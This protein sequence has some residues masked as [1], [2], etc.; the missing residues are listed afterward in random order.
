M[1]RGLE[2]FGLAKVNARSMAASVVHA[3]DSLPSFSRVPELETIETLYCPFCGYK[4]H[5]ESDC[6]IKTRIEV[7]DSVKRKF[8]KR[9]KG[10][11]GSSKI[12]K[13]SKSKFRERFDS[14]RALGGTAPLVV[15]IQP[16]IRTIYENVCDCL[17]PESEV[18]DGA[19]CEE[20]ER[21][22]LNFGESNSIADFLSRLWI[23]QHDEKINASA[24][25]I[26]KEEDDNGL[27]CF[28]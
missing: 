10:G 7:K 8:R 12:E 11:K 22:F 9:F 19:G 3:I 24:V 16:D 25:V 2:A 1:V 26:L 21:S 6:K 13:R 14:Y 15:L 20:E 23:E 5:S 4:G 17:L 27:G 28:S 18:S